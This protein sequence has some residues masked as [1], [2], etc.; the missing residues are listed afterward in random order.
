MERRYEELMKERT[1]FYKR[2]KQCYCP[3]LKETVYFTSKGFYHFKY[4]GLGHARS[5]K[6]RMYRVGLLP[7]IKPVIKMAKLSVYSP[8]VYKKS[9]N[10]YVEFWKL[11]AI[12][13]RQK[14]KVP[15]VLR[16]VGKGNIAFYS[17]WKKSDKKKT[18][19][20]PSPKKTVS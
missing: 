6:E 7:L 2:L 3:V 8:P 11:E 5:R 9:L 14:T 10:K 15:V 16:R 12:V 19:K 13:G 17:V 4:N 1:A 18:T 20:K